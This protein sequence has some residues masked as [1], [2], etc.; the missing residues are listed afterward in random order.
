[1]GP[2]QIANEL[3]QRGIEIPSVHKKINRGNRS[4]EYGLWTNKTVKNRQYLLK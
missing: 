1:M 2:T 3:S 4:L